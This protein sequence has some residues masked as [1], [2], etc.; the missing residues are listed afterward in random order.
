MAW[1]LCTVPA[2]RHRLTGVCQLGKVRKAE[3]PDDEDEVNQEDEDD[4]EEEI[5]EDDDYQMVTPL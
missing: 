3:G 4:E 5:A 1:I 2:C